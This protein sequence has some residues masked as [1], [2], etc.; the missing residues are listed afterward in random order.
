[1]WHVVLV[2]I[3]FLFYDVS[4]TASV[5]CSGG[6]AGGLGGPETAIVMAM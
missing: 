6:V 1:M 4:E 5:N 2:I 3:G